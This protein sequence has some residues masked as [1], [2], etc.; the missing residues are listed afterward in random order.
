MLLI[1][2]DKRQTYFFPKMY[3]KLEIR[4]KCSWPRNA[5]GSW[6]ELIDDKT[7]L[8]ED[9]KQVFT[10]F[11]WLLEKI[12]FVKTYKKTLLGCPRTR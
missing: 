12:L 5:W 3:S 1:R 8:V 9:A 10:E 2:I 6:I 7:S 11:F 4:E